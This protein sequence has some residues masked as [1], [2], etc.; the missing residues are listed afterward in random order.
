MPFSRLQAISSLTVRVRRV[1]FPWAAQLDTEMRHFGM[2]GTSRAKTTSQAA[3]TCRAVQRRLSCL[4][5]GFSV[6]ASAIR[7]LSWAV[8]IRPGEREANEPRPGDG[9]RTTATLGTA[10]QAEVGGL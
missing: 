2:S 10:A 7:G 1:Y 5:A 3:L 4:R 9:Q 8:D 6:V